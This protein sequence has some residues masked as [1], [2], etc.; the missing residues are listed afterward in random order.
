MA[1][2]LVFVALHQDLYN[3]AW[4]VHEAEE[5]PLGSDSEADLAELG[6]ASILGHD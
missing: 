1:S 3:A 6:C 4:V 5:P 2:R